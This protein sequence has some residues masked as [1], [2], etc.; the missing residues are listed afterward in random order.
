MENEL[1]IYID[2][3]AITNPGSSV[4]CAGLIVYPEDLNLA[5][6][7][8]RW[9]YS[10]GTSGSMELLALVNALKWINKNTQELFEQGIAS[11]TILSDSQYIV[12]SVNSSLYRWSDPFNK[13][14]WKRLDGG[15]VK[16]QSLW[17]DVVRERRKL[18]FSLSIEW[19][20][21]KSTS[22][23]KAVD[24]AAKEA[25]VNVSK[26]PNFAQM[27]YK[28]GRSL[29][30][31]TS[32][33]QLITEIG[34]T[35]LIY[36]GSHNVA[37]RRKDAEYE[38]RF[39]IIKDDHIEGPFKAYTSQEIGFSSIDRGNY[40]YAT[41]NDNVALPWIVEIRTLEESEVVPLKAKV[42]AILKKL[43]SA[44]SSL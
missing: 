12:K 32:T 43:K 35:H 6:K 17:K 26:R 7:V 11:I 28:Q 34:Q 29:L 31:R 14:K 41:F 2:G 8:L 21:G 44:S 20:K 4:G 3:S 27:P 19:F 40:Y 36:V 16:H 5:D 10:S 13:D 33:L 39:E 23:T 22:E 18:K 9:P 24:K 38:V 30:G 25:S 1:K 15:T 37:S 42:K